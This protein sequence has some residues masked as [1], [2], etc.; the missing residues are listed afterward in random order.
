MMTVTRLALRPREHAETLDIV[1]DR[2]HEEGTLRP[3]IVPHRVHQGGVHA[4]VQEL[5]VE[6][7][8]TCK[9]H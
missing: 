9:L 5:L 3:R 7:H 8:A 2:V 4:H 6:Q 1:D